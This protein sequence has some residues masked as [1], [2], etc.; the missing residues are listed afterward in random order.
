[1]E[2]P[3]YGTWQNTES[4]ASQKASTDTP[5]ELETLAAPPAEE[6]GDESSYESNDS[7]K[8]G[9]SSDTDSDGQEILTP[10]PE[11]LNRQ[12]Q[13]QPSKAVGGESSP[14]EEVC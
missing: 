1:M 9:G 8:S 3:R 7:P 6:P 11:T 4:S 13:G 2:A 12:H 14:F 10:G 5:M